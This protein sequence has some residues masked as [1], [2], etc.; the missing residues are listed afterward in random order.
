MIRK[1][2]VVCI[3]QVAHI[4]HCVLRAVMYLI[5][6]PNGQMR[7]KIKKLK[8]RTSDLGTWSTNIS[9]KQYLMNTG[10]VFLLNHSLSF[11]QY[12]PCVYVQPFIFFMKRFHVN[13]QCP[14]LHNLY[15]QITWYRLI[16]PRTTECPGG[17][18]GDPVCVR[19]YFWGGIVLIL[20]VK[21]L[22]TVWGRVS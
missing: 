15:V 21:T 11:I 22:N 7:M 9:S 18:L 14:L 8:K 3:L 10:H 1:E 20:V 19:E 6:K 4:K 13:F 5:K 12:R 2:Q 16:V 17:M